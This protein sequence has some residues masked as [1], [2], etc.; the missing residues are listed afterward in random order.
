MAS[1]DTSES[2]NSRVLMFGV[3]EAL[4]LVVV[5]AYQIYSIKSFFEAKRVI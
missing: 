5:C 4:V 1:R 2:T 3:F